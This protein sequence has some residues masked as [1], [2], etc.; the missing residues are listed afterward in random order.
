RK[1]SGHEAMTRE[2]RFD[3]RVGVG[4]GHEDQ[5]LVARTGINADPAQR[6]EMRFDGVARRSRRRLVE[7]RET[8][9]PQ[10]C[11]AV[12]LASDRIA[13][14]KEPRERESA[15]VFGQMDQQ[16]VVARAK[17]AEQR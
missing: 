7:M 11:T 17:R 12:A 15:G 1:R 16:L 8:L 14:T 5:T 3:F 4:A 6:V 9:P 10:W 2:Q 13:R